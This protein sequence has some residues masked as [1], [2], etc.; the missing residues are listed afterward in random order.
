ML[1][2]VVY[3]TLWKLKLT[4]HSD[5][6]VCFTAKKKFGLGFQVQKEVLLHPDH[7]GGVE[8]GRGDR[9]HRRAV[10]GAEDHRQRGRHEGLRLDSLPS[11][12]DRQGRELFGRLEFCRKD[13]PVFVEPAAGPGHRD[14]GDPDRRREE[15]P[16]E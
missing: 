5:D 12:S 8:R 13:F 10:H 15:E 16:G 9:L 4:R 11:V 2:T 6:I 3:Q 1:P 7:R 14:R